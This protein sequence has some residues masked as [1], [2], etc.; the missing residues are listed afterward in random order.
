MLPPQAV[1]APTDMNIEDKGETLAVDGI[2]EL[3]AG[4]A[5]LVR[6]EVRAALKDSH[7]TITVDLSDT[8]FLDSSGLGTLISLHKTMMGRSGVVRLLNPTPVATQV[9]EL[10]RM[11][12]IFEIVRD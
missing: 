11:H 1:F 6:D 9:L 10:T 5:S 8:S 3:A 7:S 2:G 12:R 4:N